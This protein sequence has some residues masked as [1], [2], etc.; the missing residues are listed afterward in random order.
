[1][2][3]TKGCQFAVVD[4]SRI[5]YPQQRDPMATWE[6][7]VKSA[8]VAI[9]TLIA[10]IG[11]VLIIVIVVL[12][13]KM[14]TTTNFYIVNLAVADLLVACF[15]MWI[16]VTKNLTDGWVLGAFMCKFNA[17]VQSK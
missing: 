14:R 1:M 5:P 11:N 2:A 4:I 3:A 15:P 10:V 12:S 16:Y 7:V 17:S 6:V 9:L 13:K 8:L